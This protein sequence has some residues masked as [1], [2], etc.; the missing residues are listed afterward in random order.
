MDNFIKILQIIYYI[1]FI[2][3]GIL[4]IAGIIFLLLANPLGRFNQGFG[5]PPGG[6]DFGPGSQRDFGPPSSENQQREQSR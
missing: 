3:L 1:I 5:G 6:G 4:L 2:P